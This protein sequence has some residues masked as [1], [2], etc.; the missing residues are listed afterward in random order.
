MVLVSKSFRL[1]FLQKNGNLV[2][3]RFANQHTS[4]ALCPPTAGFTPPSNND[5]NSL[6]SFHNN[7]KNR[8]T[9]SQRLRVDVITFSQADGA[10]IWTPGQQLENQQ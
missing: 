6:L 9:V 3:N 7:F 8:S 5:I 4:D 2:G 10:V 1:I